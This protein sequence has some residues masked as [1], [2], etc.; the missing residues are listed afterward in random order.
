MNNISISVNCFMSIHM[1]PLQDTVAGFNHYSI[2]L[3]GCWFENS[4]NKQKIIPDRLYK[5]FS[6][7]SGRNS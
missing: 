1:E 7:I 6:F 5:T 2:Y 4:F 3:N